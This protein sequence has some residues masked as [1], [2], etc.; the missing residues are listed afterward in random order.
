MSIPNTA[1][2][3]CAMPVSLPEPGVVT[4]VSTVTEP[5]GSTR[6]VE[7]SKPRKKLPLKSAPSGV[8]SKPT[9]TP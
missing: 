1:A 4:P 5:E 9:P 6:T 8:I 7:V 2:T 3:I